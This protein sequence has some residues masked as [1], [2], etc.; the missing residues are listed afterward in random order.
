MLLENSIVFAYDWFLLTV[1]CK[2][3]EVLAALAHR[4]SPSFCFGPPK[5]LDTSILSFRNSY[6]LPKIGKCGH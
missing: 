5:N 3:S 6:L 4:T 2:T 1:K